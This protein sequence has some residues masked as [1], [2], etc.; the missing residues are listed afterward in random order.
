LEKRKAESE[1]KASN[2]N[3]QHP[4]HNPRCG[5]RIQ[6]GRAVLSAPRVICTQ[7][8]IFAISRHRHEWQ[9]L[10][11]L[12]IEHWIF[13]GAWIVKLGSFQN[14]SREGT[15][16][17]KF[18]RTAT[19]PVPSPWGRGPGWGRAFNQLLSESSAASFPVPRILFNPVNSV[20]PSNPE[21]EFN[22]EAPEPEMAQSETAL[23]GCV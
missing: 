22:A 8:V 19:V 14:L 1:I 4:S 7:R 18:L 12:Q 13:S 9:T 5:P 2:S 16:A 15:K 21:T 11:C 23:R 10:G 6:V 20:Q 3:V 17:A